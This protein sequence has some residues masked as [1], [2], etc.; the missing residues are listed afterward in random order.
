MV[1][2]LMYRD[3]ESVDSTWITFGEREAVCPFG[4]IGWKK[5]L[6]SWLLDRDTQQGR[7]HDG[8]CRKFHRGLCRFT[9]VAGREP[10]TDQLPRCEEVRLTLLGLCRSVLLIRVVVQDYAPIVDA[11][12]IGMRA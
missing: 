1:G 4:L 8:Y 11:D 5:V 9:M 10:I 6:L 3:G 12:T 7:G 2:E